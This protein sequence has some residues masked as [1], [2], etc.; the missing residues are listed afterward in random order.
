[1]TGAT[2]FVGRH[3]ARAFVA[4]GAEVHATRRTTVTT[5]GDI[6]WHDASTPAADLVAR[7]APS[8]VL[9]GAT[10][11][12]RRAGDA[13]AVQWVNHDWPAAL[14]D[15]AA[16]AR[17]PL[18]VNVDTSLPATLNDYARTKRA[19]SALARARAAAADLRVLNVALESVY[20]PGDDAEKFQMQLLHALLR[21]DPVIALTPGDQARDYIY[22]DDAVDGIVRLV[23]HAAAAATPYLVGGVGTGTPVTIRHFAETMHA[24]TG[25][26]SRLDF[27]ARPY[28]PGEL[29]EARADITLLRSIGWPTPRPIAEG[30]RLM[31]AAERN[32][33]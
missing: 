7:V 25:S 21:D 4:G 20:G 17:V 2:G 13:A 12:G 22:I 15:A 24:L 26:R 27:G 11:Y 30:L 18:F 14:L 8:V 32:R 3:V 9:H 6:T 16:R 19:F 1:M 29:M 23:R 33:A 28:R 5:A 31:I 10:N